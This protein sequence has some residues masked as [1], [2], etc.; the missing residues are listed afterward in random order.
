MRGERFCENCMF[1]EKCTPVEQ[2]QDNRDFECP[3]YV[4]IDCEEEYDKNY[5][6]A[7]WKKYV[8]TSWNY[9]ESKK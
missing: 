8:D 6:S 7:S 2:Q 5:R 3:N 9:K 4:D 1:F